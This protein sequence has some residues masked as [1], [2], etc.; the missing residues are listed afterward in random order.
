MKMYVLIVKRVV[1]LATAK[2]ILEAATAV[3]DGMNEVVCKEKI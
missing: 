2:L 1:M 3:L